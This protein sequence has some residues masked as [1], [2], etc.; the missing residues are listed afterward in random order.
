MGQI[1]LAV[2]GFPE[3]ISNKKREIFNSYYDK[4]FT[5]NVNLLS[6]TTIDNIISFRK[7]EKIYSASEY[8]DTTQKNMY[9]LY[10]CNHYNIHNYNSVIDKFESYLKEYSN[11]Q[12][13]SDSKA[14]SRYLIDANF[15]EAITMHFKI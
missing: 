2:S 1:L 8:K 10:L 7:I 11:I 9:I 12:N 4:L 3:Q 5:N 15:R 6:Q 14:E 13:S